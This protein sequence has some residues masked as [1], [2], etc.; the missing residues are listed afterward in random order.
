MLLLRGSCNTCLAFSSLLCEQIEL[1][2]LTKYPFSV[3][4]IG[5]FD[6]F[7]DNCRCDEVGEDEQEFKDDEHDTDDD[8]DDTDSFLFIPK[9]WS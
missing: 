1:P 2:P 7:V 4:E 5:Y 3:L 8:E 9:P 6:C